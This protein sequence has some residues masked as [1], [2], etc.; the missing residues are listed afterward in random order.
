LARLFDREADLDS[1]PI[2][3]AER[4]FLD[5]AI[6]H[7]ATCF[8]L[9]QNGKL[10]SRDALERDARSFFC[11]PLPRFVW[12]E[13]G[14]SRDPRFVAFIETCLGEVPKTCG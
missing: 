5:V 9:A 13:S 10:V 11:L 12:D 3:V 6:Y 2:T 4:E 7:F 1:A 8:D 14:E